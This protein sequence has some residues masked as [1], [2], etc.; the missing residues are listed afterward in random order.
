MIASIFDSSL[1]ESFANFLP[2][3]VKGLALLVIGWLVAL[4]ME[5]LLDK[6][7][8][9]AKFNV[10]CEKIGVTALLQKG[11]ISRRPSKVFAVIVYWLVIIVV[12]LLAASAIGVQDVQVVL[13]D[14]L[15]FIPKVIV[16]LVIIIFGSL[17]AG[18]IGSVVQT[19]ASNAN[20]THP[21]LLSGVT[22]VVIL[23]FAIIM[24]LDKL[25]IGERVGHAFEILLAAV[26]LACAISFGLGC[27]DKA[28]EIASKFLK[29]I[30]E[31]EQK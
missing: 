20:I 26:A 2:N 14:I 13:T 11:D 9:M 30:E 15:S 28:G 24:A 31:K 23:I 6:L 4:L 10:L 19:A 27:K 16:A 12:I 22:K 29:S 3:L 7:L 17:L 21:K 18:L 8:N 5:L 1:A 25:G